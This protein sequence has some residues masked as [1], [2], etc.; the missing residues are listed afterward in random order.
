MPII[1]YDFWDI[2]NVKILK[3]THVI[4]FEGFFEISKTVDWLGVWFVTG[5]V[6][7]K[8]FICNVY[9]ICQTWQVSTLIDWLNW[10]TQPIL[11][12]W[13]NKISKFSPVLRVT[14][15]TQIAIQ[16]KKTFKINLHSVK[17]EVEGNI[18]LIMDLFSHE[19]AIYKRNSF[20]I[21]IL[22]FETFVQKRSGLQ[23]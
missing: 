11:K 10:D 15:K 8:I 2:F 23:H 22:K 12:W 20:E 9:F 17:H 6:K 1:E 5:N 19:N 13:K 4:F 3:K 14:G 16:P 7:Y 18:I 21:N